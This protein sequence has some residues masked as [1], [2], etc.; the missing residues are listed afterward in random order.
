MSFFFF[1]ECVCDEAVDPD[2]CYGKYHRF[3]SLSEKNVTQTIFPALNL[4]ITTASLQE[5]T[6]TMI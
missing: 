4:W 1:Y 3:F 6:P 5:Q 2:E